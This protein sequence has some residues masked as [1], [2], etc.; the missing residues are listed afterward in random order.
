LDHSD[1]ELP[2]VRHGGQG[3][4]DVARVLV[5][6]CISGVPV[7]DVGGRVLGIVSE[8]DVLFKEQGAEPVGGDLVAG[9][10]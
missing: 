8:A 6:H 9:L 3:L 4:D 10:R 5:E 1:I 2:E 7:C